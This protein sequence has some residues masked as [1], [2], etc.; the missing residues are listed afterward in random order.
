MGRLSASL[1][2]ISLAAVLAVA[3]SACGDSG[4]D[5]L[6]GRTAAEIESNL[7]EVA[8]LAGEDECIGAADAAEQVRADVDSLGGV[9]AELK[10]ALSEGVARLNELVAGCEEEEEPVEEEVESFEPEEELEPAEKAEKPK[11]EKKGEKAAKPEKETPESEE[12]EGEAN[13]ELPA[14]SNGK[15]KGLENGNGPPSEDGGTPSGGVAP[16]T[17]VEGGD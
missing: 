6:P 16:S 12:P 2:A 8:R 14:Q 17:P 7:D 10:R 15:G 13:P 4:A 1:L 11:K 9:D 5:L 3:L